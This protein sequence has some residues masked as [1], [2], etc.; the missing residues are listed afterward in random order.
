MKPRCCQRRSSSVCIAMRVAESL[1]VRKPGAL[2][3]RAVVTVPTLIRV[4]P[5]HFEHG[6]AHLPS[7]IRATGSRASVLSPARATRVRGDARGCFAAAV[8]IDGARA[9]EAESSALQRKDEFLAMLGREPRNHSR[10]SSRRRARPPSWQALE[11]EL[12]ILERQ[13]KHLVRVADDLHDISRF[14]SGKLVLYPS[15]SRSPTSLVHRLRA[16]E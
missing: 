7:P 4:R 5:L 3:A 11:R 10:S 12:G 16:G 6:R 1:V 8:A 2:V 13:S 15:R 9:Y 14:A